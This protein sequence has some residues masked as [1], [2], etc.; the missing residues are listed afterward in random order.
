MLT[1]ILDDKQLM[2]L[3]VL[4]K[5]AQKCVVCGHVSPDGD[6]MGSCLGWAEYLRKIGKDVAVVM[7]SHC[8]D[9][10]KWLPGAQQ[11][12]WLSLIHI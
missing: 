2:Q 1:N 11:I 7:P 4:L 9:F 10:L 5:G 12:V 6:A 3:M 8:P